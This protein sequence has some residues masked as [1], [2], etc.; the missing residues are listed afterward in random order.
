MNIMVSFLLAAVL[1]AIVALLYAP[2][3]GEVLRAWMQEEVSAERERLQA[4]HERNVQ[5]LH[6]RVDK[7]YGGVQSLLEQSETSGK[8][9][10]ETTE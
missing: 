3:S 7:V 5:D 1:D 4:Q 2:Q 8:Q 6:E 9:A 10:T